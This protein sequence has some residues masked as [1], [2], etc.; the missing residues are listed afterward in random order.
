[1]RSMWFCHSPS[2]W[3]WRVVAGGK[4]ADVQ[5]GPAETLDLGRLSIREKP[6]GDPALIEHLDRPRLKAARTRAGQVLAVAPLDDR[7]VDP[8]QR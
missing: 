6:I 1:M 7:D 3:L 8:R 5:G 2:P 4:V